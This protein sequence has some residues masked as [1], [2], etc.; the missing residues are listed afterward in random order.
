MTTMAPL[1]EWRDLT[2][3]LPGRATGDDELAAPWRRGD[4]AAL[5][6]SRGAWALAALVRWWQGEGDR[7]ARL[8][9]PDYFC[10]ASTEAARDAGA[11]LVFYPVGED[12]HPQWPAL[13]ALARSAPPDL[14]V[15]VHYFGHA[16]DC[17]TA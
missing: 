2:A 15:A 6:F 7:P 1:P 3:L 12:L 5:W 16:A 13:R 8:W 9:L 4:E 11:E 17:R 14:F 10:N